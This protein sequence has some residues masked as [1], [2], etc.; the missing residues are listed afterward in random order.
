MG[1]GLPVS[2]LTELRFVHIS[3]RA[4]DG[5]FFRMSQHLMLSFIYESSEPSAYFQLDAEHMPFPSIDWVPACV[6]VNVCEGDAGKCAKMCLV[7]SEYE[8]V[9]S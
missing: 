6:C 8:S 7:S 4:P 3:L 9:L 1:V 5:I 2:D